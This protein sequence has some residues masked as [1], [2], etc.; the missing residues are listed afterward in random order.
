MKP[1]VLVIIPTIGRSSLN[2][3][4]ESAQSQVGISSTIVVV[5]DSTSQDLVVAEGVSLLKTGG[6]RGPA[7]ARNLALG[8]LNEEYVAFLDDDDFW[9]PEKCILQISLMSKQN[10]LASFHSAH[11]SSGLIRPRRLMNFSTNPLKELYGFRNLVLRELYLPFPSLIL[12]GAL[13]KKIRFDNSLREREDIDFMMKIFGITDRIEQFAGAWV[14]I[15]KHQRMSIKRISFRSDFAWARYLYRNAG[16]YYFF[17][18]I[19]GHVLRNRLGV[20]LKMSE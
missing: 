20:L 2:Y 7:F 11:I 12:T 15:S 6:G 14:T 8:T 17:V 5:D 18:F 3:A 4:I 1:Q 10:L 13:A 9:S 16:L 19:L